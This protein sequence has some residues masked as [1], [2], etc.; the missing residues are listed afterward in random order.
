MSTTPLPLLTVY[1]DDSCPLCHAE[2]AIYRRLPEAQA[3]AWVDVSTGQDLGGLSCHAAMA[4]FHVRDQQG[5]IFSGAA[6]F[7]HMWRLF[8]G[9]RWIGWLSAYPPM[10]WFFELCYRSFLPVRPTLQKWV[11]RWSDE[12]KP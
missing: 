11:R 3:M 6:A 2:I 5:Q 7:S 4:R 9:W 12:A 1:F 10:S 8:P